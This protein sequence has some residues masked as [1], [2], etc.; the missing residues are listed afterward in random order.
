MI[1]DRRSLLAGAGMALAAGLMPRQAA[2]LATSEALVLAPAMRAD[3]S[4]AVMV[5]SERG[6][7][8]PRDRAAGARRMTLPCIRT[9]GRAVAFARRPGTFAVAFDIFER[10]R[11]AGFRRA[12]G[13]ALLRPRRL[14]VGR[15]AAL[16][17]RERFCRRR[18]RDRHLRRDGLLQAHRRVSDARRRHARGDPASRRQDARHRQRRDRD[19]SGLRPRDAEYP[20]DGSRRSPSSISTGI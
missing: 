12:A 14:F 11:A 18:G 8:D 4:F 3:G 9:S 19:A 10:S 6:E 2:A 17:D 5:F 16:R 13:P 7:L 20:D 1:V 15:Q